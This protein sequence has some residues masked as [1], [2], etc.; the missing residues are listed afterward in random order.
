MRWVNKLLRLVVVLL[1]LISLT[2]FAGT[3]NCFAFSSTMAAE[4]LSSQVQSN[5]ITQPQVK[6]Q[7]LKQVKNTIRSLAKYQQQIEFLQK[8]DSLEANN[9]YRELSQQLSEIG[10]NS[11]EKLIRNCQEYL[12]TCELLE[13]T[14]ILR[15]D[16]A[17]IETRLKDISKLL[18]YLQQKE[19]KLSHFLKTD[20]PVS[21]EERDEINSLMAKTQSIIDRQI[22]LPEG[23]ELGRLEQEIFNQLRKT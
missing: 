9:Y 8:E 6:R 21:L 12:G 17:W 3:K 16:L 7:L 18:G 1:L 13:R 19:W 11:H 5:G 14:A 20:T 23:M 22:P 2:G 10:V 15:H 4:N